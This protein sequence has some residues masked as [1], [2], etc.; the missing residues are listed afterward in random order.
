MWTT[1]VGNFGHAASDAPTPRKWFPHGA[2]RLSPLANGWKQL[3]IRQQHNGHKA[4]RTQVDR[5]A[6]HDSR[7]ETPPLGQTHNFDNKL[8]AN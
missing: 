4:H 6:V 2:V 3:Q 1:L 7:C 8:S 5:T